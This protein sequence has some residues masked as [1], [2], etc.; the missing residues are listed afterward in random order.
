MVAI[1]P[2]E[3]KILCMQRHIPSQEKPRA[4][5]SGK[6]CIC[7]DTYTF[8]PFV[9]ET[10][11]TKRL[12]LI[13]FSTAAACQT[14]QHLGSSGVKENVSSSWKRTM[15]PVPPGKR[16]SGVWKL[17]VGVVSH[18]QRLQKPHFQ[19]KLSYVFMHLLVFYITASEYLRHYFIELWALEIDIVSG[20]RHHLCFGFSHEV[21]RSHFELIRN[22]FI[23]LCTSPY[24]LQMKAL[25]RKCGSLET[26]FLLNLVGQKMI[27]NPANV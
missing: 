20:D 17:L 19:F 7:L 6:I 2:C 3:I 12:W 4:L 24:Y 23:H 8:Y 26:L 15:A 10:V 22:I 14:L 1:K 25:W 21:L 5:C 18:Y 16:N 13:V 9:L 11:C 27:K